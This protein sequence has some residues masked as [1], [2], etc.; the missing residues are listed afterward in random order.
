M[1]NISEMTVGSPKHGISVCISTTVVSMHRCGADNVIY[2]N[3]WYL[4]LRLKPSLWVLPRI[5]CWWIDYL[6]CCRR[7][8]FVYT[9][10]ISLVPSWNVPTNS[11][12]WWRLTSTTWSYLVWSK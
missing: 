5:W 3:C 6:S 9:M 11:M 8:Q 12:Q 4:A 7:E 2:Y 10:W 1:L